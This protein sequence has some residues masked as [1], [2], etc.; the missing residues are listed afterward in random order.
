MLLTAL[1]VSLLSSDAQAAT[2]GAVLRCD[3]TAIE[4]GAYG[5]YWWPLWHA[6]A[7]AI[8]GGDPLTRGAVRSNAAHHLMV[9]LEDTHPFNLYEVY[10][11]PTGADPVTDR[12]LLG[13][14]MTDCDGD[15]AQLI[16]PLSRPID[17]AAAAP[18]RFDALVGTQESGELW[19]YSRGPYGSVDNGACRPSV[20]NTSDGTA[21]GTFNN[22]TLW[23]GMSLFDGLQFLT[24]VS[25][26]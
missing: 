17:L 25:A 21:S 11:V 7:P 16:R 2:L 1:A 18:A 8:C 13:Q 26:R 20:L 12:T 19:F 24:G 14:V 5:L 3:D 15:A 22:P 23:G 4:A 9:Y 10:F 6:G